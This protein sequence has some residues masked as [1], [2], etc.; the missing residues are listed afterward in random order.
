[1]ARLRAAVEASQNY[2]KAAQAQYKNGLVTYLIVI[3]AERT[4]LTNQLTLS[5]NVN[6]RI[7]ASIHLIKAL[8]GGWDAGN[9]VAAN[10]GMNKPDKGA[11]P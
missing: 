9:A 2:L 11:S 6:Q 10:D 5:Q 8:G 1:M 4:L 3:D 7:S